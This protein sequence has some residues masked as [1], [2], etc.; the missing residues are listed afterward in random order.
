MTFEDIR[1]Y[2][3]TSYRFTQRTGMSPSSFL[4][5]KYKGYI[6]IASQHRLEQITEGKLIADTAHDPLFDET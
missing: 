4:H 1:K 5:W 2:Y 6:P 3:K